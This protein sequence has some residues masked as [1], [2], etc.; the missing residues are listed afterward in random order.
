MAAASGP[1]T[2]YQIYTYIPSS[3][4]LSAEENQPYARE[5]TMESA[6]IARDK[7]GVQDFV[8]LEDYRS[9]G[10]FMENLRKRFKETLIYVSRRQS[11]ELAVGP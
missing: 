4:L 6:L 10:A 2:R 1:E 7:I 9:E 11:S 5:M 8:L 3:N